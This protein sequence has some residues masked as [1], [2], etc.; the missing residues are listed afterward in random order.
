MKNLVLIC[1][2]V[3]GLSNAPLPAG[4]VVTLTDSPTVNGKLTLNPSAI[5][6]GGAS[7]IDINL[8]D[9]LEADFGETPFQLKYFFSFGDASTQLPTA[10]KGQDIGHI[11]PPGT[12]LYANGTLT[13]TGGGTETK[14]ADIFSFVGLPWTTDGQW[15]ARVK[16]ID[17]QGPL[18]EVGIMLREGLE[19]DSPQVALGASANIKKKQ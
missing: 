10:W 15:T 7:P 12:V 1:G 19:P 16:Q 14:G 18:T 6:V 4:D 11:D 13:L 3:F 5:H 9:V 2:F 17:N 8:T